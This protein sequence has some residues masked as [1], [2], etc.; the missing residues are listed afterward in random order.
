MIDLIARFRGVLYIIY[1]RLT[2]TKVQFGKGL[3]LYKKLSIIGPGRI[4]LGD[5]CVIRGIRGDRSQYVTLDTHSPDAIIT[6]GDNAVLCAARISARFM[7][8]IGNDVHI[9][10]AGIVDTDFHTI[11]KTRETPQ[12]ETLEKCRITIS[13][14]VRIGSRSMLTKGIL[15]GSDVVIAPGSVVSASLKSGCLAMGNPARPV[16][17]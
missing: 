10:E 2:G 9:E 1:C 5:N 15:I 8:T 16:A 12:S 7:I 4:I 3:Q 6:I 14:R 13:D 11:G 17:E